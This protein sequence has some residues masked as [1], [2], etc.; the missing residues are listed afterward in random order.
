MKT[1]P[2]CARVVSGLGCL[3]GCLSPESESRDGGRCSLNDF[4]P[5]KAAGV[6]CYVYL[7]YALGEENKI[8]TRA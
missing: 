8:Q 5:G 7:L 4:K 1:R 2:E 3:N 6:N